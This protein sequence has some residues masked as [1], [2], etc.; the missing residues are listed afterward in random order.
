MQVHWPIDANLMAHFAGSHT[1][2]TSS[3]QPPHLPSPPLLTWY[4][5]IRGRVGEHGGVTK[6]E[7]PP[8]TK[9]FADLMALQREDKIKHIGVSNFGVQQ[10][11]EALATG[12]TIACNQLC[13]NL[14]FRAAEFEI[15]SRSSRSASHTASGCLPT[16]P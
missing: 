8:V 4:E 3:D 11:K 1:V 9:A 12:V 10:L 2:C 15:Y 5:I 7:V 6:S 16:R 13:Y 14:I